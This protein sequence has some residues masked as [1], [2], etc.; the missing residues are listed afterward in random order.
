VLTSK[1]PDVDQSPW[2]T[3]K[4][5]AEHWR[6]SARRLLEQ[7][8]WSGSARS[9][10]WVQDR[11]L[12]AFRKAGPSGEMLRSVY[13]RLNLKAKDARQTAQDLVRAGLLVEITIDGAEAYAIPPGNGNVD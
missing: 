8:D 1:S 11:V 10:R 3:G 2:Q 13:R 5:I 9:E 7:L 6:A 12:E 4:A